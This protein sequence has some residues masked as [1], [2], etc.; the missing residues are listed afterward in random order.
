MRRLNDILAVCI[1]ALTAVLLAVLG[2]KAYHTHVE[3]EELERQEEEQIM[4]EVYARNV[5]AHNRVQEMQVEIQEMTQDHEKL[6]A[7]IMQLQE[8]SALRE[9]EIARAEKASIEEG[10]GLRG[11]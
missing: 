9:E 8:E 4:A 5:E 2:L 10:M 6:E 1:L 11:E 7:F 3:S